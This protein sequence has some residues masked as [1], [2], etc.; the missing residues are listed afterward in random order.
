MRKT[1]INQSVTDGRVLVKT[2]QRRAAA[3]SGQLRQSIRRLR[4]AVIG[5]E[6]AGAGNETASVRVEIG[7]VPGC[8][9]LEAGV[10]R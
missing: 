1:H 2:G 8:A 5:M 9:G 3:R 4:Y 6:K 10:D 7:H